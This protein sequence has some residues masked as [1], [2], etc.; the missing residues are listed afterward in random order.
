MHDAFR[1]AY[2][3]GS[4][5]FNNCVFFSSLPQINR[6]RVSPTCMTTTVYITDTPDR[7][8]DRHTDKPVGDVSRDVAS[9]AA[10]RA[11]DVAYRY[12]RN[13]AAECGQTD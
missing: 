2:V 13:R 7:Q 6:V 9:F 10:W 11:A 4:L 3:M 12:D 8:R 1:V 5:F